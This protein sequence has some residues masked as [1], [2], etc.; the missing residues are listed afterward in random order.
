[1][2]ESS[3]GD[4]RFSIG[5]R[6]EDLLVPGGPVVHGQEWV[7]QEG[8]RALDVR[9]IQRA[10]RQVV[11]E[12]RGSGREWERGRDLGRGRLERRV[13]GREAGEGRG[14]RRPKKVR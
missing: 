10:V 8:R 12:D 3:S 7:G 1:V 9:C 14:T 4:G 6:P 2:G 13:L 5:D 11:L